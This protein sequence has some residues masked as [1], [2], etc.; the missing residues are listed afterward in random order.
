MKQIIKHCL[1]VVG[2]CLGLAVLLW[3]LTPIA[4]PKDNR[5]EYGMEEIRANGFLAE[6]KNSI[7][8]AIIGDS[9]TY[10]A[11]LPPQLWRDYG[12]TSY[13]LGTNTQR[14][15][16]SDYYL[17]RL[18]KHQRPKVV[19]LETNALYTDTGYGKVVNS[20]FGQYFPVIR[21]HDRWKTL[22]SA[23]FAGRPVY[24]NRMAGKGCDYREKIVPAD[25]SNYMLPT[26]EVSPVLGK[27]QLIMRHF[28]AVCRQNGVQLLL[29]SGPSVA[30]WYTSRHNAVVQLAQTLD[31]PYIDMNMLREEVPIDWEKETVDAGDHLNYD[32]AVKAT[33]Y[34]GE[35]LITHYDLA[36]HRQDEAYA[37]W[38]SDIEAFY[39]SMNR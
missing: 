19:I 34:L 17:H 3:L 22:R 35:Y 10:C 24:T 1:H 20:K 33:A 11:F 37:D 14:I 39:Q 36:D 8:V 7:D 12:V 6:R 30:N 13:V 32:G 23:D 26:D 16:E 5:T 15:Y 29:V 31:V 27:N 4:V 25:T 18:L 28:A 2:F 38:Q 9:E 21:Y